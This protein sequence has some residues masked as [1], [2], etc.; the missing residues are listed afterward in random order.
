MNI[1]S[2][3][4]RSHFKLFCFVMLLIVDS[5][6]M[7][8][9]DSHPFQENCLELFVENAIDQSINASRKVKQDSPNIPSIYHFYRSHVMKYCCDAVKRMT[10]QENC[11]D[12]NHHVGNFD[13]CIVF[14]LIISLSL[15]TIP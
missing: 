15:K 4:F 9:L 11:N 5:A 1:F 8:T 7:K 14:V 2:I 6:F 10:G 12:C 13:F 3:D